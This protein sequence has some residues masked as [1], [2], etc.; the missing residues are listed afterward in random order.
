MSYGNS[1]WPASILKQAPDPGVEPSEAFYDYRLYLSNHFNPDFPDTPLIEQWTLNINQHLP[2]SGNQAVWSSDAP[3]LD[4]A[5]KYSDWGVIKFNLYDNTLGVGGGSMQ[6]VNT[7]CSPIANP[8]S[9]N[10][11]F[12]IFMSPNSPVQGNMFTLGGDMWV[13]FN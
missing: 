2:N 8:T 9:P 10:P 6:V 4:V 7:P 13:I 5:S 1:N 3:E 12:L 11:E